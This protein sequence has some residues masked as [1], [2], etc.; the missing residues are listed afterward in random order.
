[1]WSLEVVSCSLIKKILSFLLMDV[2]MDVR[3]LCLFKHEGLWPFCQDTQSGTED[4]LFPTPE[5]VSNP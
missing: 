2:I 5:A 4:P 3:I 1:M